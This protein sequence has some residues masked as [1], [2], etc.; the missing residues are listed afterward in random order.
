MFH[1]FTGVDITVSRRG[2]RNRDGDRTP[3]TSHTV[4]NVLVDWSPPDASAVDG[5]GQSAERRDIVVLH[6]PTGSD[7]RR[8]DQVSL[9]GVAFR[10]DGSPAP[11]RF[12][13]SSMDAGLSVR[14]VE[15]TASDVDTK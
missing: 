7:I 10:V 3:G 13:F 9:N 11:W 15:V 8:G 5:V 1:H 6:C 14:C 4:S 12:A 2:K